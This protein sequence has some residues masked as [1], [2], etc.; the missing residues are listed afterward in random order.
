VDGLGSTVRFSYAAGLA[1]DRKARLAR[2]Q[3]HQGSLT[4]Q[5]FELSSKLGWAVKKLR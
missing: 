1:L 4:V 5:E 3:G 2:K